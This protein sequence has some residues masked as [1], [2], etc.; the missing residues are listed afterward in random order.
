MNKARKGHL[1]AALSAAEADLQ[2]AFAELRS[3]KG[4]DTQQKLAEAH[5]KRMEKEDEKTTA[6]VRELQAKREDSEK[7]LS[8]ARH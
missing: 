7:Q 5:L 3:S 8:T 6:Q 4:L 1:T 2:T